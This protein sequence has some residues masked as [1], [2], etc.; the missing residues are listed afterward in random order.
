MKSYKNSSSTVVWQV[1]RGL[2]HPLSIIDYT[3][4]EK[5]CQTKNK[6]L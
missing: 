5:I 1:D 2:A 4:I 6:V 3:S